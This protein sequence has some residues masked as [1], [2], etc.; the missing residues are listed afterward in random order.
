MNR[1]HALR[2][3]RY[4]VR[5]I[6]PPEQSFESGAFPHCRHFCR[7]LSCLPCREV[8]HQKPTGEI[9][10]KPAVVRVVSLCTG[11]ARTA[12][13]GNRAPASVTREFP[14]DGV[15]KPRLTA[16]ELEVLA[17]LCEGL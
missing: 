14:A 6:A 17:L 3:A 9:A 7:D 10:M 11:P 2:S 5:P 1:S 16:R 12:S 15:R 8:R 4:P 13:S